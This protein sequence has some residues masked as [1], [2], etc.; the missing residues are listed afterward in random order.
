MNH[1]HYHKMFN[2]I[3]LVQFC[4]DDRIAVRADQNIA[5]TLKK[6]KEKRWKWTAMGRRFA[7][8]SNAFGDVSLFEFSTDNF[9]LIAF[10]NE[11]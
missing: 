8:M 6:L 7:K 3:H 9:D 5:N 1:H 11:T 4:Y 10:T 2:C